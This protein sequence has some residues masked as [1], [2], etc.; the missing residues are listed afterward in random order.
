MKIP[1]ALDNKTSSP[2]QRQTVAMLPRTVLLVIVA[3]SQMVP[4]GFCCTTDWRGSCDAAGWNVRVESCPC[5]NTS[6]TTVYC[7]SLA[8]AIGYVQ[9]HYQRASVTIDLCS[10]CSFELEAN[11]T[12]DN[13][14]VERLYLSG[15]GSVV[16]CT[17]NV[18]VTFSGKM[19]VTIESITFKNC[20]TKGTLRFVNVFGYQDITLAHFEGSGLSFLN[21]SGTVSISNTTISGLHVHKSLDH[22]SAL[23]VNSKL[24]YGDA[25]LVFSLTNCSI[26]DNINVNETT[27]MEEMTR[28]TGMFLYLKRARNSNHFFINNCTF[29]NNVAYL[30]GSISVLT[31]SASDTEVDIRDSVFRGNK[32]EIGSATDF[33][34]AQTPVNKQINETCLRVVIR[35][36][37]FARNEPFTHIMQMGSSTVCV[38][39]TELELNGKIVFYKN[40]GSAIA[41]EESDIFVNRDS[42]ITFTGNVAQRGAGLNLF[43]SFVHIYRNTEIKFY[44]TER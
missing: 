4:L 34:C 18:S 7:D 40:N 11:S 21:V 5:D 16:D 38:K 13:S 10:S 3:A 23:Y 17:R 33:Y 8:G 35:D 30:G 14:N 25:G 19:N 15:N 41:S 42:N 39:Y 9:E 32:A 31:S 20:S 29:A 24:S 2:V 26:V 27:A 28:G 12:I 22:I 37:H 1:Q 36:S 44:T 6:C 43:G